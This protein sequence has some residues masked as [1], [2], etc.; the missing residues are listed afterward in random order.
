[1]KWNCIEGRL[2]LK[3]LLMIAMLNAFSAED[4]CKRPMT[5]YE[6][7]EG[8]PLECRLSTCTEELIYADRAEVGKNVSNFLSSVH[9]S[10]TI[11]MVGNT[12]SY[13]VASLVE[14]VHKG[15]GPAL[16]LMNVKLIDESFAKLKT[17]K[18][19]DISN[20]CDGSSELIKIEGSI[21]QPILDRLQKKW[22]IRPWLPASHIRLLSRQFSARPSEEQEYRAR[23]LPRH[24]A[25]HRLWSDSGPSDC[26]H[27]FDDH[28]PQALLLQ[29]QEGPSLSFLRSF[30]SPEG[31]GEGDHLLDGFF[32]T[33]GI[34]T[35][36]CRT[37]GLA[38]VSEN[39]AKLSK[40]LRVSSMP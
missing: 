17:I 32:P 9:K 4:C 8:F 36:A 24:A 21:P 37:Y 5:A 33:G 7:E 15:P 2:S 25:V 23:T 40:T 29:P 27:R 31:I 13:I 10:S 1:M 35:D 18:V 34:P 22:K 20:Y 11:T 19:D 30:L 26:E 6:A 38:R 28:R 39:S 12:T 16:T 3:L 14:I